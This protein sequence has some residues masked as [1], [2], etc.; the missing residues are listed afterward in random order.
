M[1]NW[2]PQFALAGPPF[3]W[4]GPLKPFRTRLRFFDLALEYRPLRRSVPKVWVLRPEISKRTHPYHPHLNSD[5]SVCAYF[6]PDAS[7]DPAVHDISILVDI[8]GDWL[9]RH[10]FYEEFGWWPGPEAPHHARSVLQELRSRDGAP[11]ICGSGR[12]FRLCCRR[13]YEHIDR[14]LAAGEARP[15][16]PHQ[17]LNPGVLEEILAG[18]RR[19]FGPVRTAELLPHLGPPARLLK[20]YGRP[21]RPHW[22]GRAVRADPTIPSRTPHP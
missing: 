11:C 2:Y 18:I 12:S 5:G 14:A 17:D 20:R 3:T 9:R 4:I 22:E 21:R 7:Y 8:V 16:S 19:A 13:R 15:I 6:V 10:I 1:E